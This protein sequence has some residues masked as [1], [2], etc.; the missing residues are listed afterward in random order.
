[1]FGRLRVALAALIAATRKKHDEE[2]IRRLQA[3]AAKALGKPELAMANLE[4]IEAI[5]RMHA[6]EVSEWVEPNAIKEGRGGP[7]N[8]CDL[9]HWLALAEAAGVPFIEA[10]EVLSLTE[11]EMAFLSGTIEIPDNAMSRGLQ[12]RMEKVPE[13]KAQMEA[14]AAAREAAAANPPAPGEQERRRQESREYVESLVERL[15][16]AMDDVPHDWM[17]RTNLGGSDELKAWAGAGAVDEENPTAKFSPDLEVGPGWIK[18]G[19]RRRIRPDDRRTIMLAAQGAG[20]AHFL[21]RPWMKAGRYE[22]G[23]DPHRHGTVFAGKG[24]WP[25]EWRVF[26]ERGKVVGVSA[27]YAWNGSATPENAKAAL[28]AADLAQRIVDEAKRMGAI[29]RNMDVELARAGKVAE[30]PEGQEIFARFPR[31]GHACTLDFME[32]DQGMMLLEGGPA[33]TPFGGGHPVGFAGIGGRPG[34]P[35]P[36]LCEGVA[37]RLMPGVLLTDPKTW[38]ETDRTDCILSWDDAV[39]LAHAGPRP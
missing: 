31:D 15:Y 34:F 1:M 23:E 3:I 37:F 10:R 22:H 16:A 30:M 21:A 28:E 14:M 36:M 38:R 26:V 19:N 8:A 29:P 18:D 9:R 27:Y 33:C 13:L 4:K 5:A 20:G 35:N 25:C 39:A 17:V 6:Q 2:D 11:D 12:R 32:T 7:F 24:A